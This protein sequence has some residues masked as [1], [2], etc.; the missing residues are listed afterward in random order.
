MAP[1]ALRHEASGARRVENQL[2][3]SR[4]AVL[5]EANDRVG[6]ATQAQN[7]ASQRCVRALPQARRDG[8]VMTMIDD[9][10]LLLDMTNDITPAE[11]AG[12]HAPTARQRHARDA[13]Q[14]LAPRA[15]R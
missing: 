5:L 10:H 12:R 9:V 7:D 11:P 15:P 13:H 8:G 3:T 4:W 6:G 1:F 14:F 2:D